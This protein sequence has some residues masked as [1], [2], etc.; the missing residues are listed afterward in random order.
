MW[1]LLC[2]MCRVA[3]SRMS[4][5]QTVVAQSAPDDRL[6][7]TDPASGVDTHMRVRWVIEIE[8]ERVYDVRR[9]EYS[10]CRTE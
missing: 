1:L 2:A 6:D 8:M 5:Q 4:H 10:V 3:H 9:T 7:W